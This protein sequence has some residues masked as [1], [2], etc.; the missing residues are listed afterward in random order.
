MND[1]VKRVVMNLKKKHSTNCPYEL[2]EQLDIILIIEPL[3]K[4][5]G[6]YKYINRSK[7]I[8]LNSS[9]NEEE[10]RYVLAHEIGHA[11]LHPKSSCFFSSVKNINTSKKEYEANLFAAELLLE[12]D[13]D[14][15]SYIN[16]Y[17]VNQLASCYKVP[18]ELVELKFKTMDHFNFFNF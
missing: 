15:I 2:A 17:S 11:V 6:M 9:M 13:E 5:L 10:K 3:G 14:D 7:V 16:G 4:P 12:V 8:W 1:Y 18:I